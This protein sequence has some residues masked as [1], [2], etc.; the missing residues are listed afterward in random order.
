MR[1]KRQ[2]AHQVIERASDEQRQLQPSLERNSPSGS[3]TRIKGQIVVDLPSA[4]AAAVTLATVTVT[5]AVVGD[6]ILLTPPPGGLS[7]AIAVGAAYVSAANTVKIPLINPTAGAL[8]AASATFD[9]C[10]FRSTPLVA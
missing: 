3:V 8:D 1:T 6:L 2:I 9:Y 5:G 4:G 7:V 10:V